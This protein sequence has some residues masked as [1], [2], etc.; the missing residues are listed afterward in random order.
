VP[1]K[2]RSNKVA[3]IKFSDADKL[4]SILI[5]TGWYS[6]EIT[7][8][9]GPKKST[10]GK[11]TN[12]F[13]KFQATD[14]DFRGKEFQIAFSTGSS[15]PSVLGNSQW[16]P[17]SFLIPLAAAIKNVGREEVGDFDTEDPQLLRHPFDAKIEKGIYDG[18]ALNTIL[19]FLPLGTG[20]DVKSV[21]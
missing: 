16:F 9:D 5:P 7:E 11:S 12:I 13:V 19:S 6:L 14:G 4:A 1:R 3:V 18:V 10:S 21:F 20:A 8:I 15:A 2:G 17:M